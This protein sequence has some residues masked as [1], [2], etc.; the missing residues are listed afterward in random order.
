MEEE[1]GYLINYYTVQR[2]HDICSINGA[3]SFDSCM[4]KNMYL[5]PFCTLYRKSIPVGLQN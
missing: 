2:G 3:G 4:R 5:D 1:S